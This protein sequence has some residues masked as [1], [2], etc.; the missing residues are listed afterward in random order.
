MP[1]WSTSWWWVG[2]SFLLALVWNQIAWFF[3]RSRSGAAGDAVERIKQWRY[4]SLLFQFL[5]LLY[6]V[7]LPFSALLWGRDAVVA[8]LMGLQTLSLPQQNGSGDVATTAATAA[9]WQDWARDVGWAVALGAG[10]WVLFALG[11]WAYLRATAAHTGAGDEHASGWV[12]LREAAYHEI[13]WA[14]YRNAPLLTLQDYAWGSYWGVWAGLV[15][16]GLEAVLDPAWR[17]DIGDPHRALTPLTQAALA[18]VSSVLY[19]RTE[20]L[21]L[22]IV[23]HWGVC[24][25]LGVLTPALRARSTASEIPG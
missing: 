24:W 9:N 7:G 5:R 21:W 2:G 12:A 22:A 6:Y 17:R 1:A 10:A 13:H 11:R 3:R 4:R 25:G 20:N 8:R 15:L 23:A 19:L 16:I 18:V 14:F